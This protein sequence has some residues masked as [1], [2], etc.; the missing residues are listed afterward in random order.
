[1]GDKAC[2]WELVMRVLC[3]PGHRSQMVRDFP[4][5][6]TVGVCVCVCVSQ[7]KF[8]AVKKQMETMEM[9]VMEARLIRASDLNGELDDDGSGEPIGV[10]HADC[11]A[12]QSFSH[13]SLTNVSFI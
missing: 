6:L 1:M 12:N 7:V 3:V 9:E 11:T 4:V 13:R 8:D 5:E 2:N 10:P